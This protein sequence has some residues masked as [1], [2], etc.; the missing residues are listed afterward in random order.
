MAGRL[1]IIAG[2]GG[3]VPHAI[4]AAQAAGYKVQVLSLVPRPDLTGVKV[5]TADL[6][7]P[8]G[9]I[10]SLKIFRTSHILLAG[11]F[12]LPDK[13]RD[14]LV[15]VLG[16]GDGQP[17]VSDGPVGDSTLANL[18]A[19]L[20]KFAGADLIGVHE[21]APDLLAGTGLLAGPADEPIPEAS[22]QFAIQMAKAIGQLDIGQAV[23]T[24]GKRVI[25][26]EDIGGTDALIARVGDLAKRGLAG[27]GSG[28]LVLAKAVKP[29]Q[30][31]FA[32]LPA[33][34]PDTVTRCAEA[35]ISLIAVEAGKS[36]IIDRAPMVAEATARGVSVFGI[37]PV[38]A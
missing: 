13:M 27:E 7:N 14:G 3:L 34:G 18:G 21:I 25:A 5:V 19:A 10:W 9:V 26:V 37:Q 23:V 17:K 28:Q 12:H 30:P 20:K 6:S 36:L 31:L 1:S 22:F 32:D 29:Q 4:A 33:I 38:H 15:K 2:S 8:L 16:G 35:G 24:S 11:A